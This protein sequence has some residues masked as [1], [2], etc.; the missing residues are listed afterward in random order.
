MA[1]YHGGESIDTYNRGRPSVSVNCLTVLP[2]PLHIP[3]SKLQRS[4][5]LFLTY[6]RLHHQNREPCC[7]L[8]FFSTLTGEC[9]ALRQFRPLVQEGVR[10]WW[11]VSA[12]SVALAC[13]HLQHYH[14]EGIQSM[15]L[16]VF[17]HVRVKKTI[18]NMLC[19]C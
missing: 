19:D 13:H 18:N 7:R 1:A 16:I 8:G 10:G 15:L 14:A 17:L 3:S 2:V 9:T 5:V 6:G 11:S 4:N 12:S